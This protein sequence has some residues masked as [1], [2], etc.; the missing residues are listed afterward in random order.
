MSIQTLY[1]LV[2]D[3]LYVRCRRDDDP[4]FKNPNH[5]FSRLPIVCWAPNKEQGEAL[6]KAYNEGMI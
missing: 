6:K 4:K 3:G 5:R 1:R 2:R